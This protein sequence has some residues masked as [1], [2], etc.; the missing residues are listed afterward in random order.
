MRWL[1]SSGTSTSSVGWRMHIDMRWIQISRHDDDGK[2]AETW[3]QME[4]PKLMQQLGA[5]PAPEG[6]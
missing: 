1:K 6:M 3:A 2:I 5:M 4:V